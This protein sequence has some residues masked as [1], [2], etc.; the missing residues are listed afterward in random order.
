[1]KRTISVW[2]IASLAV[3]SCGPAGPDEGWSSQALSAGS[4]GVDRAGVFSTSEAQNLKSQYGVQWTG[5]YVG[6]PCNGGSG[7][8]SSA[9]TAIY[10]AT[11]WKFMPIYVGQTACVCGAA[12]FSSGQGTTDGNDAVTIMGQYNWAPN[13]GIPICLDYEAQNPS[14]TAYVS[15]WIAAVHAGGYKAYVYSNPDNLNAFTSA[16]VSMDGIWVA[17][18]YYSSFQSGISPYSVTGVNGYTSGDR[19]WQYASDNTVGVDWDTA[20]ITL[21]PPPGQIN[22]PAPTLD[23]LPAN[24]AITLV[25]WSDGH[26]EA[27]F[28]NTGGS[29]MHVWTSGTSETWNAAQSLDTGV[30]CGSSAI[31]W[32]SPWLYTEV[33]SPLTSGSTGHLWWTSGTWNTYQAFG[34]SNLSHFETVTWQD[35]HTEVFAL[36]SDQ[37]IWHQWWELSSSAWSGWQSLGGQLTSGPGPIIWGDG[38]A[39]VFATAPGGVP[40]HIWTASTG[41]TTWTA[42]TGNLAS[43]PVPVRLKNGDVDL[44]GIGT[45]GYLYE[46]VWNNIWSAFAKIDATTP[47]FGEPSA[48]VNSNGTIEVFARDLTGQVVHTDSGASW[49]PVSPLGSSQLSQSDPFGWVRADGTVD[50]FAVDPQG[51]LMRINRDAANQWGSWQSLATAAKSCGAAI[52]EADGGLPASDAGS[53]VADAGSL[54]PDSGHVGEEDAGRTVDAGAED[55]GAA[56]NDAGE[57]NEG[58]PDAATS[59]LGPGGCG[60]GMSGSADGLL[61]ALFAGLA[62]GS[63]RSKA[64]R[65]SG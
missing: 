2:A 19:A 45:D 31:Y 40:Y 18:W 17:D 41:W 8:T 39:E 21:A 5:A 56:P 1:M 38:H 29:L 20:D 12:N 25:T 9:L 42:M 52:P 63:R 6:G 35:G 32:P 55:S 22:A 46:S 48:I 34:G 24:D 62:L 28:T 30:D 65:P 54:E 50:V 4:P 51:S 61:M 44:I 10:N 60:C 23:Q 59:S 27:F 33:F 36:G 58:S 57:P 11:G 7:W 49:A 13:G 16:N 15:A 47:L 14:T 43:R 26:I 37:A 53:H 64:A 3:V